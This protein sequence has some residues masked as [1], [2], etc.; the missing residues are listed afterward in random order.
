MARIQGAF[1]AVVVTLGLTL[2][3]VACSQTVPLTQTV[4]VTPTPQTVT[5]TAPPV[6][7]TVTATTTLPPASGISN[8][9]A[10]QLYDEYNANQVAADLKYKGKMIRVQGTI[11]NHTCPK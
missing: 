4:T 5:L 7:V 2:F 11:K 3:T 1:L 10:K 9:T 8:L 6:T